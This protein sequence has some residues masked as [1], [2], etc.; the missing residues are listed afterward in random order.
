MIHHQFRHLVPIFYRPE[1]LSPN[2]IKREELSTFPQ[3]E[4]R[5]GNARTFPFVLE[6]PTPREQRESGTESGEYPA[7]IRFHQ[8]EGSPERR[9]INRKK[10]DHERG[11]EQKRHTQQ[12]LVSPLSQ[13]CSQDQGQCFSVVKECLVMPAGSKW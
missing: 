2:R 3:E 11:S 5:N 6:Y 12:K 7:E 9:P 1:G 8:Y 10:K 13:Y 4:V